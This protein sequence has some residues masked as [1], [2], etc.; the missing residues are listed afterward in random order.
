MNNHEIVKKYKIYDL[1]LNET[2]KNPLGKIS[3][4]SD[5][6]NILIINV[7]GKNVQFNTNN[8]MLRMNGNFDCDDVLKLCEVLSMMKK[9]IVINK[10]KNDAD[11]INKKLD[12]AENIISDLLSDF[13]E[14]DSTKLKFIRNIDILRKRLNNDR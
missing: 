10:L 9:E 5:K 13:N 8:L 3:S 6:D 1:N 7:R 4:Y 14:N 12:D 11:I 2:I